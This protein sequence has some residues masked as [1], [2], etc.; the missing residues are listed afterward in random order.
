MTNIDILIPTVASFDLV[1]TAV[2]SYDRFKGNEFT[3]I[4]H[5]I[6]TTSNESEK[7]MCMSLSDNI[8]WYS[9]PEC[10]KIYQAQAQGRFYP[11]GSYVSGLAYNLAIKNLH[12]DYVFFAHN[13]TAATNTKWMKTLMNKLDEGCGVA[14]F[15]RCT[16]E[17]RIQAVHVSGFLTKSE[18]A[19]KCDTLPVYFEDGSTRMTLDVGDSITAYCRSQG[20]GEFVTKNTYNT[21][22][23]ESE[24]E[25][26]FNLIKAVKCLS[27]DDKVLYMHCGRGTDKKM[28]RYNK[29][30]GSCDLP[31]WHEFVSQI[32]EN[33]DK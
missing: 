9:M 32:M 31:T 28:G 13:D 12:S 30:N 8:V 15:I 11:G 4:Y 2:S 23:L 21:P 19:R 18:I 16:N 27:D 20:L 1:K 3:F 22:E 17:D 7:D 33:T 14:G 24:I 29:K 26:P 10:D 5:I 6:E 25:D